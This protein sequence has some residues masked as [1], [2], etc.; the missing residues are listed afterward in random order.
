MPHSW[1]RIILGVER[2]DSPVS[3]AVLELDFKCGVESIGLPPNGI[4][5]VFQLVEEVTYISVSLELFIGQLGVGPYLQWL[6][7]N[8]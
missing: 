1:K 8:M 3:S 4:A 7:K 5:L 6:D 2:H